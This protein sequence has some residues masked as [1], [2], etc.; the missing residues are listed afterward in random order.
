LVEITTKVLARK[1]GAVPL[2]DLILDRIGQKGTGKLV[3]QGS[4]DL[5]AATPAFADVV[6]ARIV[7]DAEDER[8]AASKLIAKHSLPAAAPPITVDDLENALDAAKIACS[9]QGL[10]LIQRASGGFGVDVA[11]CVRIWRG[12]CIIRGLLNVLK[13]RILPEVFEVGMHS[14]FIHCSRWRFRFGCSQAT[15]P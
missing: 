5:I 6:H 3:A 2:V 11:A 4:L 15:S 1:D 14:G 10:T 12:G 8:V 9:V 13:L 7:S